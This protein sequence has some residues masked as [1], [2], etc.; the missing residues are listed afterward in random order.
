VVNDSNSGDSKGA[1]V[2][3]SRGNVKKG[4]YIFYPQIKFLGPALCPVNG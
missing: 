3:Y 2:T 1:L 4:C